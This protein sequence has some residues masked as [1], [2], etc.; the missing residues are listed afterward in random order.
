MCSALYGVVMMRYTVVCSAL[1]GV[2]CAYRKFTVEPANLGSS[3]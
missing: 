1:Y 3:T 2:V